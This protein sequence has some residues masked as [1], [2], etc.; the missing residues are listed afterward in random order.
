MFACLHVCMSACLHVRVF[1]RMHVCMSACLHVRLVCAY[2]VVGMRA[3]MCAWLHA[4]EF[5]ICI[6]AYSLF[7]FVGIRVAVYASRRARLGLVLYC[8]VLYRIASYCIVICVCRRAVAC[9]CAPARSVTDTRQ[10]IDDRRHATGDPCAHFHSSRRRVCM[11]I[12]SHVC[13]H[14][15]LHAC[16]V[17]C[18]APC[19]RVCACAL[20]HSVGGGCACAYECIP[21]YRIQDAHVTCELLHAIDCHRLPSA[22]IGCHRLP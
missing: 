19:L 2:A 15:C 17:S 14:V 1:E 7:A 22:A 3:C 6:S 10:T 21:A 16:M 11:H 5:P 8:L 9:Y 18:G 20:A 4:L 12:C 13:L